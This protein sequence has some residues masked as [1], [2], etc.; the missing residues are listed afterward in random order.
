[1]SVS[2][3]VINHIGYPITTLRKS[4]FNLFRLRAAAVHVVVGADFLGERPRV[5][6]VSQHLVLDFHVQRFLHLIHGD[7]N[8]ATVEF[9]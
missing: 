7:G 2:M 4:I 8:L 9:M 5:V 6:V 3:S 1:M